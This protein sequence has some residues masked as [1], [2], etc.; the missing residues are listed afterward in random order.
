TGQL[1]AWVKLPLISHISDT[2]FYACYGNSAITTDQSAKSATWDTNFVGVWHLGNGVTLS[3]AD[4]TTN[5][6]NG[7]V[8]TPL[9][10]QGEIGGGALF[11][12]LNADSIQVPYTPSL[13]FGT[14]DF[15]AELWVKNTR[16]T[17]PNN[18]QL[19]SSPNRGG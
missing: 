1:A 3:T 7:T 2:P 11:N 13:H 14:G 6:N 17:S 15:T 9:P 10:T 8:S 16:A 5:A 18:E 19:L 12:Y 4:S